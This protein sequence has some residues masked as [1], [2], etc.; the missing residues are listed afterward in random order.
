[1]SVTLSIEVYQ[2]DDDWFR[3]VLLDHRGQKHGPSA[4]YASR[5]EALLA[6]EELLILNII[7]V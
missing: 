6:I 4:G 7:E 1:M 5:S 3:W 2:D